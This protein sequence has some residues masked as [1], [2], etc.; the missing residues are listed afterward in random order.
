ML[1]CSHPPPTMASHLLGTDHLC[2]SIP[3]LPKPSKSADTLKRKHTSTINEKVNKNAMFS[4][5]DAASGNVNGGRPKTSADRACDQCKVRK[6]KCSMDKPCLTCKS[7]GTDCTFDRAR[8]K[9][10]PA[11]KRLAEIQSHQR[12][13]SS[14][15]RDIVQPLASPPLTDL[16]RVAT[17]QF[18]GNGHPSSTG[19]GDSSAQWA[20]TTPSQQSSS[21]FSPVNY[22][23]AVRDMACSRAETQH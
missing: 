2:L 23:D 21:G 7:K 15:E 12:S 3:A 22:P 16:H 8:K 4:I 17:V 20:V 5:L 13:M 18:D 19:H 1:A 9:R 11:G 6:I 14:G 10:G